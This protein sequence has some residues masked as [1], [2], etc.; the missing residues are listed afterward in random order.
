MFHLNPDGTL[1]HETPTHVTKLA[2]EFFDQFKDAATSNVL[3]LKKMFEKSVNTYIENI[4]I[5]STDY[6]E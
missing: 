3:P 1:I 5:E 4:Q 2:M 6:F